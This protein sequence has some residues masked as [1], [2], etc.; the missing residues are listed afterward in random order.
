VAGRPER[1]LDPEGG[2]LVSLALGLRELRRAAGNP[3]YR[4]MARRV[5]RSQTAL[6]EAAGGIQA[7]TWDTVEAYVKACGGDPADWRTRG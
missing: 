4:E 2:P 1:L 5:H 3:S 6:S 7:P